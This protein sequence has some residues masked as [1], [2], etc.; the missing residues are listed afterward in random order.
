MSKGIAIQTILL[1]LV[2]IL[3]IGILIYLVYSYTTGSSSLSVTDCRAELTTICT[4]CSLREWAATATLTT[5]NQNVINT[6]RN[7]DDFSAFP[8][9]PANC[10]VAAFRTGCNRT[11]VI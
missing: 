3:V 8:S 1:L 2:G 10:G 7:F 11:G 6:C 5:G 4:V 9:S